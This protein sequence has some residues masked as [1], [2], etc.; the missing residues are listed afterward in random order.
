[1][2]YYPI[3][4]SPRGAYKFQLHIRD[5]NNQYQGRPKAFPK[6][7]YLRLEKHIVPFEMLTELRENDEPLMLRNE[8]IKKLRNNF[9]SMK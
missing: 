3:A 1:M 5:Y 7:S 8:S 4:P 6:N 2:N 9:S